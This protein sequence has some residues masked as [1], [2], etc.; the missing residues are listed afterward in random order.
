MGAYIDLKKAKKNCKQLNETHTKER[1]KITEEGVAKTVHVA[2]FDQKGIGFFYRNDPTIQ[3]DSRET[4][5][6]TKMNKREE[7]FKICLFFFLYNI[8]V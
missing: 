6:F 7:I 8:L 4:A 1:K 2:W 5:Y 3:R